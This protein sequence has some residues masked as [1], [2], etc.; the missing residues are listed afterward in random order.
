MR[1]FG[2]MHVADNLVRSILRASRTAEKRLR[3][4]VRGGM[5]VVVLLICGTRDM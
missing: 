3:M 1:A 5:Y 4:R 2:V